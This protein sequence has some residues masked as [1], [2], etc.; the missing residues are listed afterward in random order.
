MSESLPKSVAAWQAQRPKLWGD[1]HRDI[2]LFAPFWR[3]GAEALARFIQDAAGRRVGA[4]G[5]SLD[6]NGASGARR[7]PE[8]A[9]P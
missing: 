1:M 8:R 3:E 4:S 2:D 9:W 6:D 7:F 5:G